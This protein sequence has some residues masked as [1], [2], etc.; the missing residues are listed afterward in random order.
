MNIES[1]WTLY[2]KMGYV[3]AGL[4]WLVFGGT[5]ALWWV[6]GYLGE[7]HPVPWTFGAI[8]LI[9]QWGLVLNHWPR[10]GTQRFFR[11]SRYL[12]IE[13]ALLVLISSLFAVGFAVAP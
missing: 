8:C 9:A 7:V 12:K 10:L 4:A 6:P 3:F 2:G 13:F 1:L 11:E 5:A